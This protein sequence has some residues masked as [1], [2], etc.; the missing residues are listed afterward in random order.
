[1]E[2]K[3]KD[4]KDKDMISDPFADDTQEDLKP[5]DELDLREGESVPMPIMDKREIYKVKDRKD[6]KEKKSNS[7]GA[8]RSVNAYAKGGGAYIALA[9][10]IMT[11]I[12]LATY[13]A[14]RNVFDFPA[15]I[16]PE[17][18]VSDIFP[19]PDTSMNVISPVTEDIPSGNMKTE[20]T[21]PPV[22][23]DKTNEGSVTDPSKDTSSEGKENDTP[24]VSEKDEPYVRT[25]IMPVN[26]SIIKEFTGDT[27]VYSVT[28]N[29]YRV[30]LGVDIACPV[31]EQVKCFSDGVVINIEDTPLM[32]HTVTVD[33]GEGLISHYSNLSGV[34]PK[35]IEVGTEVKTGQVIA[36]VGESALIECGEE[37]HLHFA[38]TL[39]GTEI[40]PMEYFK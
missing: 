33:H 13:G 31:G 19:Q 36:G 9:L 22:T 18:D 21:T 27:L 32:G 25:F 40:S 4:F 7:V 3:E 11:V 2:R 1:M 23:E 34:F 5:M 39:N 16:L 14:V 24:A 20:E 8:K 35:G 10:C 38:L 12:C 28:M 26:G 37:P 29:D 17:T 30:H 15:P 6:T